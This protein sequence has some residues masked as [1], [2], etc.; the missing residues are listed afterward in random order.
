MATQTK[1]T[2]EDAL[3]LVVNAY[4]KLTVENG[5]ANTVRY[6][7]RHIPAMEI[8]DKVQTPAV[9]VVRPLGT[10]GVMAWQDGK[11]YREDVTIAVVGYLR[12]K[13]LN[14]DKERLATKGE[15]LL[16]DLKRVQLSDVHFGDRKLIKNS[17][18]VDDANDAA[19]DNEGVVVTLGLTLITFWDSTNA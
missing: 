10:T 15:I 16:S 18:L 5:Y 3:Q 13:G 17:I 4:E 7:S 9:F 2:V 8:L 19:W 11:L 6:V 14:P 1:R 12:S